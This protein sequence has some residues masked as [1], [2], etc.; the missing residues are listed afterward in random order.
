MTLQDVIAALDTAGIDAETQLGILK[1][2]NSTEEANE[3]IETPSMM[4]DATP[5]ANDPNAPSSAP[6]A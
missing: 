6:E 2:L 1:E 5:P 3:G 4:A